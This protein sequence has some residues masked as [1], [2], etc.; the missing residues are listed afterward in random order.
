M[1]KLWEKLLVK[2]LLFGL[3]AEGGI[4]DVEICSDAP[5]SSNERRKYLRLFTRR[6]SELFPRLACFLLLVCGAGDAAGQ[7]PAVEVADRRRPVVINEIVAS[8]GFG[9]EDEDGDTPDWIELANLAGGGTVNLEGWYLTDDPEDL[10]RWQ[11]PDL[12]IAGRSQAV[13]FASGKTRTALYSWQTLI[14]WGNQWRYLGATSQPPSNW[15]DLGFDA[16]SWPVGPSGFGRGDGDDAT[17]LSNDTIY[18]RHEFQLSAQDLVALEKIL[19]H[20]D[21]DDG[22]VAYLN[23]QE[24]ARF[25][26]GSPGNPPNWDDY[27][28][29]WHEAALYTG[30][31]PE[32]FEIDALSHPFVTG[33]NVLALEVHN[34]SSTSS[35][36]SLIPFLT[37]G[38]GDNRIGPG[39]SQHLV[40]LNGENHTNF[41]LSD[42]GEFLALVAPDGV[43]IVDSFAAEYPRQVLDVSYGR[44]DLPGLYYLAPPTPG[45]PNSSS[46]AYQDLSAEVMY[47]QSAGTF[48]GNFQLALTGPAPSA[49]HYTL[50]ASLPDASS[51][52]YTAPF[53]LSTTTWVR[54]RAYEQGKAPGPVTSRT[55]ISLAA[56]VSTFDSD[57]PLVVIDSFGFDIDQESWPDAPRPFRPITSAFI[58]VGASGRATITDP[59]QYT[60]Y[61]A[62]HVRGRSSA[63]FFP[64]KQ[65]R[66]ETRNEAGGD[67]VVGLLGF[68]SDSDW[69]IHAPYSDKTLMRN[70]LMYGWGQDVGQ[71]APRAQFI[72][73]FVDADGGH[74]QSSDYR[75][76]YLLMENIKQASERVDIAELKPE[77]RTEPDITGGYILSKNWF[78][79]AATDTYFVTSTYQD[80]LLYVDPGP[81]QITP[82]QRAWI[83]AHMDEF[84][85]VLAGPYYTDPVT[86]YAAHIDTDSFIDHHL[87]VEMA[88]DVDGFV[89]STYLHKDRGGKIHMGPLWDFNFALGNADFFDGESPVGWHH[90]NPFFPHT[91]RNSYKWYQR[92]NQDLEYRLRYAD[93][94]YAMRR[95]VLTN[96][97]MMAQIAGNASILDEAQQRNFARWQILGTYVVGNPP[98][99]ANRTTYQS[100][101]TYLAGWLTLRLAWMDQQ[102]DI[103]YANYPPDFEINGIPSNGG[104]IE[105]GDVLEMSDPWGGGSIYYTLDG[106]DP[107]LHGGGVS[108]SAQLYTG[109][110]TLQAT[111]RVKARV[112]SGGVWGALNEASFIHSSEQVVINEINYNSADD[113][114]PEDWVELHNVGNA[115][116]DLSGWLLRD[117]NNN[118]TFTIPYGTSISAGG[119]LVICADFVAFQGLFPGV[120]AI[121]DLG[122]GFGGGGD[123]VRLFN[124]VDQLLDIVDYDD[125][126][127]WPTEPD[128][129][130]PTLE[131][132]D[133]FFDNSSAWSWSGSAAAHGTPG[134]KNSVTQ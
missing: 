14:D 129:N 133:P 4:R 120:P 39:P 42:E 83:A 118:H 116:V 40:L 74:V 58:E 73:L 3:S 16:S 45:A 34:Y 66:F 28:T 62:M 55:Y 15:N 84:E 114:D 124:Q 115:A 5:R 32:L 35:D 87:M 65:Y 22:I 61:G 31:Q 27:A 17:Y 99:W 1:E 50:D 53:Q 60:G 21:F 67:S 68:P 97:R 8:N 121:G 47:S 117:D 19:L 131:L 100:E 36:L 78:D 134:A 113:F 128:G 76:V 106:E 104:V 63:M 92:L 125:E 49:I 93:R 18:V 109:P 90:E 88:R 70:A 108:I 119:F 30:G 82:E 96:E 12:R 69:I 57:L 9:I 79:A 112:Q 52:T 72:E 91:N 20:V 25:N 81:E 7:T 64:K 127:P 38:Y 46:A 123:Q 10:T 6:T 132:I 101:V 33:T 86:G 111:T 110:I 85:A 24:V 44:H 41:K 54:T 56:D 37:F 23:G 75:G 95:T 105:S 130:G 26:M 51:P 71:Y 107:R 2:C 80:S 59:S 102:I 122:F 98:G 94:W 103:D 43:T 13:I 29:S 48:T 77:H 89:L 11:I 126:W